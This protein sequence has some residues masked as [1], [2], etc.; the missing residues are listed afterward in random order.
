[1]SI[2]IKADRRGETHRHSRRIEFEG[3]E[4]QPHH[5]YSHRGKLF[6]P[7]LAACG[8]DHGKQPEGISIQGPLLKKD[9]TPGETIVSF[10]YITPA[11]PW[12]GQGRDFVGPDA[13]VWLLELFDIEVPSPTSEGLQVL[14]DVLHEFGPKG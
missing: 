10:K 13:P 9:G 4:P 7:V 1:M 11:S 3:A 2:T 5:A 12:W 14:E 8:W 6:I